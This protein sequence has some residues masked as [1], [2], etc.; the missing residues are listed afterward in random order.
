MELEQRP[1]V[2]GSRTHNR[3]LHQDF[4]VMTVHFWLG[5]QSIFDKMSQIEFLLV[6]YLFLSK[7]F[8]IKLFCQTIK[9]SFVCFSSIFKVHFHLS[10]YHLVFIPFSSE[11]LFYRKSATGLFFKFVFRKHSKIF[12][13]ES[14]QINYYEVAQIR[15]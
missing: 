7:L 12:T 3:G 15:S 10:I 5:F 8:F 13:I 2:S 11:I 14:I 1:S 9:L 4:G 6:I